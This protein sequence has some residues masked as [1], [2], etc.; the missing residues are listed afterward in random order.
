MGLDPASHGAVIAEVAPGSAA[1]AATLQEG[2]II[3][4]I[5]RRPVA[6]AED[7]SAALRAPRRGGHLLRVR[8]AAGT[9]FVTLPSD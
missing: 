8:G 9:R 7:A 3:L 1:A 6:S 4:E 2:E 5:D